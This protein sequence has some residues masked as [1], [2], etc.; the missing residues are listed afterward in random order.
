MLTLNHILVDLDPS[1]DSQPALNKAIELVKI[2]GAQ[3]ELF[4]AIDD[5]RYVSNWFISEEQLEQ[6]KANS[7]ASHKRWLKTYLDEVQDQGIS[8]NMEVVW[9]KPHY[10]AIINKLKS[11][12]AS[13]VIKS[14]H[15]HPTVSK[16]FFTPNDWQLLKSCPVPLLL[17][18]ETSTRPYQNLLACVDPTHIGGNH[19]GLNTEILDLSVELTQSLKL[20]THIF[21][22]CEPMGLETW[23]A[24]PEMGGISPEEHKSYLD[25]LLHKHTEL[26]KDLTAPYEFGQSQLSIKLGDPISCICEEVKS[27]HA[28]LLVLGTTYHTGLIGTT[29][30]RVLDEVSCDIL[31]VKSKQFVPV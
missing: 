1:R 24:M 26:L 22:S 28:D 21:H 15:P 23:Q 25:N 3:L 5:G 19:E 8:A 9:H 7:V 14:T 29:A 31:A 4:L 30:E 13:L 2:S 6:A 12:P 20:D 18:K 27:T 17:V 10:Q 16:I 11:F